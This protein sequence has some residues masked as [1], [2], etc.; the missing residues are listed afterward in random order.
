MFDQIAL[1]KMQEA[2]ERPGIFYWTTVDSGDDSASTS[3]VFVEFAG[4]EDDD[5]AMWFGRYI[6]M[7]LSLNNMNE[8]PQVAH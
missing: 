7:L 2:A 8:H 5:H 1:Q 3:K 6:S 4:F